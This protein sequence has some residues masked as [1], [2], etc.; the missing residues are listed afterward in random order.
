MTE[1]LVI[2][3]FPISKEK[4]TYGSAEVLNL[5]VKRYKIFIPPDTRFEQKL[6]LR[7]LAGHID[8]EFFG[9]DLYLLMK[10]DDYVLYKPERNIILDLPIR[11]SKLRRSMTK[12]INFFDDK[13][14]VKIPG[15]IK[16]GQYLKLRGLAERYNGGYS[17][18]ILLKIV[19]KKHSLRNIQGFFSSFLDGLQEFK[20]EISFTLPFLLNIGG[21]FVF[22]KSQANIQGN[23]K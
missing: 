19:E 4:L 21:E 6:R 9:E 18:N 11:L 7:G 15:N 3:P 14:D 16:E 12:R 2:L 20:F 1:R 23:Y 5:G 10:K 22:K 8:P 13:Y 17:G